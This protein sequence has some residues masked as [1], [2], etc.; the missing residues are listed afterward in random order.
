MTPTA[1]LDAIRTA[2]KYGATPCTAP[3]DSVTFTRWAKLVELL[4]MA[5]DC[6][7]LADAVA[8]ANR[9]AAEVSWP[10]NIASA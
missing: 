1:H 7:L 4:P 8:S 5:G 2:V 6:G 9:A 10:G 3:R